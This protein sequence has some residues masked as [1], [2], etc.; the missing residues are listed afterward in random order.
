M[1]R[2][3]RELFDNGSSQLLLHANVVD[4]GEIT[5]P[6]S[7]DDDSSDDDDEIEDV[8][9]DDDGAVSKGDEAVALSKVAAKVRTSN[10]IEG[11][12]RDNHR[13][14]LKKKV[15]IM[16]DYIQIQIMS[17]KDKCAAFLNDVGK[18]YA[19][20]RLNK[21]SKQSISL[22]AQRKK[23]KYEATKLIYLDMDDAAASFNRGRGEIV[24]TVVAQQSVSQI[25]DRYT[26]CDTHNKTPLNSSNAVTFPF[27]AK[28]IESLIP[29]KYKDLTALCKDLVDCTDLPWF[30][31]THR[32]SL[33]INQDKNVKI[34]DDVKKALLDFLS[35]KVPQ[36]ASVESPTSVVVLGRH[37]S[38]PRELDSEAADPSPSWWNTFCKA[39][40]VWTNHD[41]VD[42]SDEALEGF[43]NSL[44]E[45]S[46]GMEWFSV[47]NW[48]KLLCK[49]EKAEVEIPENATEFI[50]GE[51]HSGGY[52][53]N[54]DDHLL[55]TQ[56]KQ[57]VDICSEKLGWNAETV[58][59]K[60]RDRSD[61]NS[62]TR[63]VFLN[64]LNC[65]LRKN[66]PEPM[67]LWLR[68]A[69]AK[70]S[71][72]ASDILSSPIRPLKTPRISLPSVTPAI[73]MDDIHSLGN[74]T[75]PQTK[76]RVRNDKDSGGRTTTER[77]KSKPSN[78]DTQVTER[79]SLVT[80]SGRT[81]SKFA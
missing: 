76:K 23:E 36:V 51:M 59:T 49:V 2:I 14:V 26:I 13:L 57:F 21:M 19:K 46:G 5:Y 10:A 15:P 60:V 45:K 25:A 54:E 41:C 12:I 58:Y 7:D 74:P 8:V 30:K 62:F 1:C 72:D 40:Q 65:S 75:V 70:I 22:S 44:Q 3:E 9:E 29:V 80:R 63:D 18:G 17:S 56:F 42:Q 32:M 6:A 37:P 55:C 20:L 61:S 77:K 16:A 43:M 67:K 81:A 11:T 4:N 35:E 78:P 28:C 69:M 66:L 48:R 47:S 50:I 68:V 27:V 31:D 73:S 24:A 79:L 33:I 64:L 38:P 71:G 34:P 39:V 52:L 53:L